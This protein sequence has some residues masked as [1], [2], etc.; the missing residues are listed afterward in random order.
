MTLTL[1]LSRSGRNSRGNHVAAAFSLRQLHRLVGQVAGFLVSKR[2][3]HVLGRP[4]LTLFFLPFPSAL[5]LVGLFPSASSNFARASALGSATA[6]SRRRN[7]GASKITTNMTV[8]IMPTIWFARFDANSLADAARDLSQISG[9]NSFKSN[10]SPHVRQKIAFNK[11]SAPHFGQFNILVS[12]GFLRWNQ[13]YKRIALR[14]TCRCSRLRAFAGLRSAAL[15]GFLLLFRWRVLP[16]FV[17]RAVESRALEDDAGTL[18]DETP[19]RTTALR[20]RRQTIAR[21]TLEVLETI[22]AFLTFVIVRRHDNSNLK[23][24]IP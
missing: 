15:T 20:T 19:Q 4:L 8:K 9:F 17:I 24:T 13:T 10:F 5:C 11:L 23:T 14:R 6:I 18:A 7:Q 3:L 16:A 12:R 2:G 1:P 22:T 21:H